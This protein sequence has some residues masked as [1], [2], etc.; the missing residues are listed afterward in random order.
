MWKNYHDVTNDWISVGRIMIIF[1]SLTGLPI[2]DELKN[3]CI[4]K[5]QV[6]KYFSN[7]NENNNND[8]IITKPL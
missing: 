1:I 5:K 3:V 2:P 8:N 4:Y 6:I 7:N